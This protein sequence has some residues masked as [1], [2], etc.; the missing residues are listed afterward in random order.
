M[1]R[2]IFFYITTAISYPNGPPHIGHAYELVATDV[3]A[4]FKRLDGYQVMFLTGTDDHGQKM[5]QTARE[6]GI[7]PQEVADK[8]VPRFIE[9]AR[10]LNC[11][12]DDFIR[13]SEPRHHKAV[14]EIWRRMDANGDIYLDSYSGWYS[15]RDEQ[16][17]TEDELILDSNGVYRTRE[18]AQVDW[19]EEESYF[20]RLSKYQDKLL[21]HFRENPGFVL[22]ETRRNE[23]MRFIESGLRDL[24]ISR[25]SF[26]WGVS[27]PGN[28]RHIVYVWVDALTNYIT[29]LGYPDTKDQRFQ[30]FWPVDIHLIGKDIVRFHAVYWPA[31]LMSAGLPL[32]KRIF[33]HGFLLARG[34]KMSK[35]LGNVVDPFGMVDLYGVDSVRYFFLREAPFG[36]DGKYDHET[37]V[38]R[39]DAELANDFGNLAQR[40]LSM[41]AKNFQGR[42][43]KPDTLRKADIELL[44]AA[45]QLIEKA[46][47]HMMEQRLHLLAAEL[48][49]LI[50]E[51]NRYFSVQQPWSLRVEDPQRMGTVLYVT[52]ETLRQA[53]LLAQSIMPEASERL[54]DL[55]GVPPNCRDFSFAGAKSRL[56]ANSP[57][58]PPRAIFPRF[59]LRKSTQGVP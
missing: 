8:L 59:A 52:A 31:F 9:M 53:A 39:I 49:A 17:L 44:A 21:A 37:M 41:I 19:V 7:A 3:I 54:L 51:A 36:E 58:P 5:Y 27:V 34:E 32:P 56:V 48:F 12:Y 43:P 18:G 45:D 23:M 57:L 55:L 24:S 6:Q 10:R 47:I 28:T 29:A 16:F 2:K 1:E 13:T 33:S 46:R 11:S 14:A 30:K 20:F 15:V 42:V 35:S 22:P 50:V 25:T 40:S 38:R 26:S 4:R